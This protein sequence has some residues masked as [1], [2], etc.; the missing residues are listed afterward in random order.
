MKEETK[1]QITAYLE[2]PPDHTALVIQIQNENI[3][4]T[5]LRDFLT[6]LENSICLDLYGYRENLFRSNSHLDS[7]FYMKKF[8][9]IVVT[10]KLHHRSTYLKMLSG[11]SMVTRKKYEKPFSTK[12]PQKIIFI[13]REMRVIPP[14]LIRRS[15]IITV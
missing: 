11:G 3:E 15:T 6:S 1:K 5:E 4:H 10:N 8:A 13:V 9:V 14:S 12:Y 2:S 7:I